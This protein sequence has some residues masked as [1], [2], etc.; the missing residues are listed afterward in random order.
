MTFCYLSWLEI[1]I[2]DTLYTGINVA[3]ILSLISDLFEYID[4]KNQNM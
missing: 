4:H 1:Y 2:F 3:Y